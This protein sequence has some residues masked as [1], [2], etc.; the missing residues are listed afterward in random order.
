MK[1]TFLIQDLFQQ[2]A[3]YVTALM[4]TGFADKGYDVDVLVSKIH[5]NLLN[6]SDIKP[7]PVPSKV[8]IRILGDERARNNIYQIREYIKNNGSD[9]IIVMDPNYATALALASI[10]LRNRPKLAYVEHS[11]IAGIDRHT[12]EI[13]K[14]NYFSPVW[15]FKRFILKQFDTLM[16]VSAGT[17][18]AVEQSMKLKENFVHV[19][20]NPVVDKTYTEK[21]KMKA[22]HPWL[23]KKICPVV[24]AA[25]AHCGIK[26]HK[27]LFKAIKKA[28]ERTKVKL[29]LFGKGT[30]TEE[31]KKWILENDM[32]EFIDLPGHTDNLP[33]EIKGADAFIVSSN[34]ESFSVVLVEALAAGTPVVA[35]DCPFGP[36]EILRDGK[37]GTLVP[38]EDSEAMANAIVDVVSKP[39]VDVDIR[40]W[41]PYTVENVVEAYI[42]A[43][44]N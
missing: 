37:F 2:G 3:Q 20:Y 41:Q 27:M 28:N 5:E 16:A 42:N 8:N 7:F 32:S 22:L 36:P 17:A 6:N 33:A 43:L 19:V 21:I 23:A 4:A 13:L 10:G 15:E 39:K 29:I 31:Y 38:V 26:N 25:G 24:I 9:I 11:G 1:I 30:L 44:N 34:R 14:P 40:S 35:T 12:N 18:K